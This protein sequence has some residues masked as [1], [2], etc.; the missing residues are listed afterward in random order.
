MTD[1]EYAE[2]Q[3]RFIALE[4]LLLPLAASHSAVQV[5]IDSLEQPVDL[6]VEDDPELAESARAFA[7]NIERWR[8]EYASRLR[9][10]LEPAD[11]SQ[12]PS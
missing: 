11:P 2:L 7:G 8:H 3:A 10:M 12:N 4:N 5:F 9:A 6:G 1:N